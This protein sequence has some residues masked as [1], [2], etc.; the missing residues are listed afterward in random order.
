MRP[1]AINVLALALLGL[2]S[3]SL[4]VGRSVFT[5]L[6]RG[7][8]A[9]YAETGEGKGGSAHLLLTGVLDHRD[10]EIPETNTSSSMSLFEYVFKNRTLMS[11]VSRESLE[12]YGGSCLELNESVV[13]LQR[14][15]DV[16]YDESLAYMHGLWEHELLISQ[17]RDM[18]QRLRP[19]GVS[20]NQTL[21]GHLR[22]MEQ[23]WE[24]LRSQVALKQ[25]LVGMKTLDG[26]TLVSDLVFDHEADRN[27]T[28]KNLKSIAVW[29]RSEF[30]YYYDSCLKCNNK[31]GNSF[32]GYIRPSFDE[33]GFR[34]GRTELYHCS[35]CRAVSR[36]PRFNALDRVLDTRRGRCGEYSMLM[37]RVLYLLG[38]EVRWV[39]DWADHVW[40][41]ARVCDEWTHIDPCEAAVDEPL[42]YQGWGKNQTYILAMAFGQGVEDVT[43]RYTSDAEAAFSRREESTELINAALQSASRFLMNIAIPQSEN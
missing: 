29:F 23:L 38:Y 2:P 28:L 42:I 43:H 35:V 13:L 37:Y 17:T 21:F 32:V 16:S 27:K 19:G 14:E 8:G 5:A 30:P 7:E 3:F 34:A 6:L 25:L 36:F 24:D 39:V 15:I 33:R 9:L 41:E 1:P 26:D 22:R 4:F 12:L 20:F 31:E 10:L 18:F 40:C 11:S